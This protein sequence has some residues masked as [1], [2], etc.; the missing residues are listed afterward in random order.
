LELHGR[1]QALKPP[2]SAQTESLGHS[3]DEVQSYSVQY[4]DCA[5]VSHTCPTPH[6]AEA[7]QASP[8][9]GVQP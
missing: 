2:K 5:V 1:M 4:P 7:V 3:A 6:S 9:S 8:T